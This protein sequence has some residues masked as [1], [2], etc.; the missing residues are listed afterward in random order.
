[1][2]IIVAESTVRQLV[3]AQQRKEKP[4]YVPLAFVPGERA[5]FD[6]GHAQVLLGGKRV[7]LPFLA[8]RLRYS[9]ATLIRAITVNTLCPLNEALLEWLRRDSYFKART[10]GT[11]LHVLRWRGSWRTSRPICCSGMPSTR[12]GS[13]ITPHTHWSI[14]P[15]RRSAASG[16][17]GGS[18]RSWSSSCRRDGRLARALFAG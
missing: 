18:K 6:F 10:R 5:E 11:G 4:V 2:G 7:R 16:S 3:R 8:D 14:W 1:M 9:G 12:S 13:L 17:P 15:M